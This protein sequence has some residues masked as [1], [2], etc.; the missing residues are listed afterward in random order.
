VLTPYLGQM[1]ALRRALSQG[2]IGVL[3]SELDLDALTKEGLDDDDNDDT[4]ASSTTKT[5]AAASTAAAAAVAAAAAS[6]SSGKAKQQHH[7]AALRVST[8]DNYQGEG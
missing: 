6:K 7:K 4:A 5:T 3:I 8:V 2:A 1:R